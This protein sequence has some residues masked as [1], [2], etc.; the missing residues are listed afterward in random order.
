MRT[1]RLAHLILLYHPNISSDSKHHEA[2]Q[3]ITFF[4]F[5]LLLV[6]HVQ[7][8]PRDHNQSIVIEL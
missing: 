2:P 8:F 6:S 1:V 3:Y 7:T 4:V 5:T